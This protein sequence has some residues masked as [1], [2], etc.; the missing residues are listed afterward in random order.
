MPAGVVAFL[1]VHQGMEFLT[2]TLVL[3]LSLALALAGA[4]SMLVLTFAL[5]NPTRGA[6]QAPRPVPTSPARQQQ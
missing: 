1:L 3:L 5:M 6:G 4:R 2:L